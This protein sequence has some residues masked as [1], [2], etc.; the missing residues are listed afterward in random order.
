M[1]D[2]RPKLLLTTSPFLKKRNDA[3]WMMW[4]V[5]CALVPVVAVAVLF[6]GVSALLVIGASTAGA[7]LPEWVYA[8]RSGARNTLRDGSAVITGVLLGLT[9]PPGVPLWMAFVG[10][11]VAIAMGKLLFGGLGSSIFNPALVGRAFLQ[12][13]FPVALT[14]WAAPVRIGEWFTSYD[15]T[16]TPPLLKSDVDAVSEATPLAQAKFEA[17]YSEV[18]ELLFGTTA[19]SLGETSALVILLCGAYLAVRGV[20][21]WRIPVS[22]FAAGWPW[23]QRFTCSNRRRTRRR[24]TTCS[25]AASSSAPS[26]W[27]PTR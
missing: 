2:R 13:A 25:P 6:F 23:A 19:G 26:S 5:N 15:A 18:P 21:N 12:A 14:T 7:L 27:P 22:I 9:L 17:V 1:P 11:V 16:F 4:Q 8:W 20:I 10:G 3:V 24:S